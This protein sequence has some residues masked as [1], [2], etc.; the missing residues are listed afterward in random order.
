[1]REM[2]ASEAS[3]NFAAVLDEAEH[4]ETVVV[5]RGGRQVATIAPAPRGN[6]HALRQV[7]EHWRGRTGVDATF[8][9][10]VEDA[11]QNLDAEQDTD[12]WH[13]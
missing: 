11:R 13:V 2:S 6:G 12:P 4:G 10:G 1:M 8:A 9:E 5:T 3:R 7:L